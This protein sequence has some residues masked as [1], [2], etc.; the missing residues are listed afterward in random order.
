LDY[1]SNGNFQDKI[2]N[3]VT[4]LLCL[5]KDFTM[6]GGK[7]KPGANFKYI[8]GTLDLYGRSLL[9]FA[10]DIFEPM[11]RWLEEYVK[12][13]REETTINIALEYFNSSTAKA[14]VRFLTIAKKLEDKSRLT[15]NYYFDDENVFEY[16][17]DFSE[18]LDLS[19][20][21]IEKNYH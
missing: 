10:E 2:Y 17:R 7:L 13:P 16:G 11:N 19:F 20:N 15:I 4:K 5:M 1:Q 21:F 12:D 18:V 14:L 3:N 9:E 6:E 8:E